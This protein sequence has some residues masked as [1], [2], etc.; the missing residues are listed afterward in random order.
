MQSSVQQKSFRTQNVVQTD[1]QEKSRIRTHVCFGGLQ[2]PTA[3]NWSNILSAL[4]KI[5]FAK[6]LFNGL[7][8]IIIL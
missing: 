4:F 6:K 2:I 3:Q 5:L 1:G 8:A 7:S